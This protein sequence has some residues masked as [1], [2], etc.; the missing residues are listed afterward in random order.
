MWRDD[1]DLGEVRVRIAVCPLTERE[2]IAVKIS[3]DKL[4]VCVGGQA[5]VSRYLKGRL[6]HA[7]KVERSVWDLHGEG[8][9]RRLEIKMCKR[10]RAQSWLRLFRESEVESE[11]FVWRMPRDTKVRELR[12]ANE[13]ELEEIWKMAG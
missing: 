9:S 5:D 3:R 10:V 11:M 13:R 2:D 6:Q 4:D 8:E 7:V 12:E 1:G